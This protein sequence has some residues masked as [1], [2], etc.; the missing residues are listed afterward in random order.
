MNWITFTHY[1]VQDYLRHWCAY[2]IP[3]LTRIHPFRYPI[4]KTHAVTFHLLKPLNKSYNT[5][6]LKEHAHFYQKAGPSGINKA[7]R[8]SMCIKAT[9]NSD[10]RSE[11]SPW[12]NSQLVHS[13]CPVEW[14][15]VCTNE[16]A[17]RRCIGRAKEDRKLISI[18]VRLK[19]S[20]M[21]L[22][23]S[24]SQNQTVGYRLKVLVQ[25]RLH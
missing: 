25:N 11:I 2:P 6:V 3:H 20:V 18:L 21:H 14:K 24:G 4:I 16:Q 12:F 13:L 15:F 19:S 10:T 1:N 8:L 17:S 22:N 23:G 5:I 7:N 9:F